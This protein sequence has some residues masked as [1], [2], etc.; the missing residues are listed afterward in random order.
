[1][2]VCAPDAA[3]YFL[4]R[5]KGYCVGSDYFCRKLHRSVE[6]VYG[7]LGERYF[8]R[9]YSMLYESFWHLHRKLS[10]RIAKAV[11]D[12]LGTTSGREAWGGNYKLPPVPN[13][14]VTTHVWLACA[15]WYFAG[16]SPYG[17]MAK[18]G[19]CKKSVSEGVWAVV[20]AVI[21]LDEF[22]IEYPDSEEVQLKIAHKFQSVSE[23]TFSNSAGA[24]NGILIWIL[25]PSEEDAAKA[26]CGRKTF[27]VV[28]RESLD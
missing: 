24:I 18:Y 7:C 8:G 14:P 17:I 12:S 15:L 1:V 6:D 11:G 16:A 22:I 2:P 19:I 3:N 23:V 9:A 26:G 4:S 10:P 28:A 20:E 25:K 27:F 21:T 5:K 13:V